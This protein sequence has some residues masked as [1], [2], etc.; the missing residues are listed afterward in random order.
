M[1]LLDGVKDFGGLLSFD[2]LWDALAKQERVTKTLEDYYHLTSFGMPWPNR[3]WFNG[4]T[5]MTP[6]LNSDTGGRFRSFISSPKAEGYIL[7][8]ETLSERRV[9]TYLC[10]G[11]VPLEVER[12]NIY[13][14]NQQYPRDINTPTMSIRNKMNPFLL[15]CSV[16]DEHRLDLLTAMAG[17]NK[18][19][20]QH[21]WMKIR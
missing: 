2:E 5:L 19:A 10:Y 3:R 21:Y 18:K 8:S 7:N 15:K 14:Q 4:W 13:P 1:K 16:L 17:S 11:C 12:G 6:P 9:I 20:L